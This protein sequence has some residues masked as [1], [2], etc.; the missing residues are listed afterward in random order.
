V[1]SI[2]ELDHEVLT[3]NELELEKVTRGHGE[4]THMRCDV[5]RADDLEIEKERVS[6]ATAEQAVGYRP[7]PGPGSVGGWLTR[8][9]RLLVLPG[10]HATPLPTATVPGAP[11]V[12]SSRASV[13]SAR[14]AA[15]VVTACR[16]DCSAFDRP[17][18]G[19]S[20]PGA[21]RGPRGT[22][23]DDTGVRSSRSRPG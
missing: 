19:P 15:P 21:E 12:N 3:G 18:L 2:G 10:V 4:G 23:A 5:L 17:V 20:S 16:R 9:D 7:T 13:P 8:H 14:V 11:P 6:K 1:V 22:L